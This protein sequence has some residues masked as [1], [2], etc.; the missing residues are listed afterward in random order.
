MQVIGSESTID[1]Q[2]L[3]TQPPI[4]INNNQETPVL[5]N[6]PG[7]DSINVVREFLALFIGLF[8]ALDVCVLGWRP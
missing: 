1:R 5:T 2:C 7:M 3:L 8:G 6:F 4:T